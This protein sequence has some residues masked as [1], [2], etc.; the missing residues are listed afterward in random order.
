VREKE[1][2]DERERERERERREG[3]TSEEG[4]RRNRKIS[5]F[6]FSRRETWGFQITRGP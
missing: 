4:G 5:F 1:E 6:S 3:A 2:K